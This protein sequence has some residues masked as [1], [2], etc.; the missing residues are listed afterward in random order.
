MG[1]VIFAGSGTL[2][3]RVCSHA[4]KKLFQSIS[5]ILNGEYSNSIK[6]TFSCSSSGCGPPRRRRRAGRLRQRE[7]RDD[8]WTAPNARK[9]RALE[10]LSSPASSPKSIG[11]GALDGV[12]Q[13]EFLA[14]HPQAHESRGFGRH[15]RLGRPLFLSIFKKGRMGR[16]RS[17]HCVPVAQNSPMVGLAKRTC[18]KGGEW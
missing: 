12:G 1:G 4:Q 17:Q 2:G 15:G 13:L 10:I 5:L 11:I 18:R 16:E 9:D 6:L 7:L 8:A 14:V 3:N